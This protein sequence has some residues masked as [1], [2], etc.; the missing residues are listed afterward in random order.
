[1]KIYKNKFKN[2][3]KYCLDSNSKIYKYCLPKENILFQHLHPLSYYRFI[4]IYKRT[5]QKYHASFKVSEN[6]VS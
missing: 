1:M 5:K 4:P 3:S 2:I 6:I